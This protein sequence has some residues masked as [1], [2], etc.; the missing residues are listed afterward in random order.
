MAHSESD[1][2]TDQKAPRVERPFLQQIKRR[3]WNAIR[4]AWIPYVPPPEKMAHKPDPGL[5]KLPT[6]LSLDI[7]VTS[8]RFPDVAG[9]R[10]NALAEALFLYQKA[11]N[12]RRSVEVLSNNG[13]QSWCMFNAYHCAYISAKGILTLLGVPLAYLHRQVLIDL[14]P[15]KPQRPTKKHPVGDPGATEFLVLPLSN[16]DQ[17]G[18]W[19]IFQRL[20]NVSKV[21]C[22][23]ESLLGR[24]KKLNPDDIT[25]PRNHFLYKA[26]YWPLEDVTSDMAFD[27][28]KFFSG[29]LEQDCD[30]FLLQ[31]CYTT[32]KMFEDLL[33]DMTEAG[34]LDM[35]AILQQERSSNYSTFCE[36]WA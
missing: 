15:E 28:E 31:L 34:S 21:D 29:D 11:T 23:Q 7:K 8:E 30:G 25:P 33:K 16:L 1:A 3:N 26:A 32:Y 22:W 2:V 27:V 19:K 24:L 20:I 6:L 10:G 14:F 18:L 36:S 9:L 12:V 35:T 17:R 13:K 4:D 5:E